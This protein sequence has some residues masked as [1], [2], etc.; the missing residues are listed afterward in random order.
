MIKAPSRKIYG[1]YNS[2]GYA[3][4]CQWVSSSDSFIFTFENDHDTHNMKIGRVTIACDPWKT[5]SCSEENFHECYGP[6]FNFRDHL[7][8]DGG[9][10]LFLGNPGYYNNIFTFTCNVRNV[11]NVHYMFFEEVEEIEEIEVFSVVKG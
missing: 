10:Q 7:Y 1:G 8:Y 5:E 11:H 3:C 6:I 4:R 2:F 9:K